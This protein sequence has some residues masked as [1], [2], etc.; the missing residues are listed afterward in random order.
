M[1]TGMFLIEIGLLAFGAWL[2][3]ILVIVRF[4]WNACRLR[5]TLEAA[6]ES[7]GAS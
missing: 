3:G 6:A 4:N 2:L 1:E 5:D 7:G